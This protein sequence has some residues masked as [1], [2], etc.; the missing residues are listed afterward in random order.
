GTKLEYINLPK[1][2]VIA[3]DLP[4]EFDART[5]WPGKMRP[6]RNQ[7]R[8]GSC[9]SFGANEALS[10]RFAIA[11]V[12]VILSPQYTVSCDSSDMGCNGGWLDNVW[13]FF[14]TH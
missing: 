5:A 7:G 8:C 11:D 3:N 6:V 9:W 10:N 14:E 13:R 12:D 2:H 4:T 1:R